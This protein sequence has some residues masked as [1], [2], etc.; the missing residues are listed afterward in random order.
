MQEKTDTNFSEAKE[1]DLQFKMRLFIV[2]AISF[3]LPGSDGCVQYERG[4][5]ALEWL[6]WN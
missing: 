1:I 3:V 6:E 5:D 4:L 2:I